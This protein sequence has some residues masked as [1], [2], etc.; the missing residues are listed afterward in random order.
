MLGAA[1]VT[2]APVVGGCAYHHSTSHA[3]PAYLAEHPPATRPGL[4]NFAP[5][6]P[7]LYRGAQPTAEGFREL[8]R[9]GV[10]TV[11]N[12]RSMH[13]DQEMLA[14]TN[15]KYVRIPSTAWGIDR[16][17]LRQFL[18]IVN[19]PAMQ[20]VFVHCQHGADRTGYVVAAYR[21][22]HLGWDAESATADLHTFGFHKIWGH[23]PAKLKTLG[24][25]QNRKAPA[26]P[27]APIDLLGPARPGVEAPTP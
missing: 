13:C 3:E 11:V 14:G 7:T 4:T 27:T 16:A 21:M 6:S 2:I 18:A 22:T 20:P 8:E 19:D 15:L 5:V 10:K 17:Q 25:E 9:M 1:W 26:K 23:I 24:V 12:L